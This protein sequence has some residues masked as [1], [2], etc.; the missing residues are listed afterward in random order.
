MSEVE[1]THKKKSHKVLIGLG[2]AVLIGGAAYA[3]SSFAGQSGWGM[4]HGM[5]HG[6]GYGMGNNHMQ[7]MFETMDANQDGKITAAEMEATR[8]QRFSDADGDGNSMISLDEFEGM[9][10]S[11]MK[12][13]MVDRFQMHDDDGDGNI[14]A[15]E[16]TEHMS[17]MTYWMDKNNDGAIEKDEIGRHRGMMG[18]RGECSRFD[19]D[20][21]DDKS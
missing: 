12:P 20:D 2:V 11:H 13:R 21:D 15:D 9:W 3:G 5:G 16:M 8:N 18:M 7:Q 17:K 14:S 19:N 6:M 10:M 1:K 4:G